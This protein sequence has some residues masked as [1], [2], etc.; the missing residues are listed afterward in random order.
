MAKKRKEIYSETYVA[1]TEITPQMRAALIQW[2]QEGKIK[3]YAQRAAILED[4]TESLQVKFDEL[5]R[6]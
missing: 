2:L 1:G 4:N 6:K 3:V 5:P